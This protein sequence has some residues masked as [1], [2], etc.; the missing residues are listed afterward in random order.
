MSKIVFREITF[1]EITDHIGHSYRGF[2][3]LDQKIRPSSGVL[4]LRPVSL[5]YDTDLRPILYYFLTYFFAARPTPL[6][7]IGSSLDGPIEDVLDVCVLPIIC[8][9]MMISGQIYG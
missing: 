9:I 2:F 4:S 6:F 7:L 1:I 5:E 3:E 8:Q